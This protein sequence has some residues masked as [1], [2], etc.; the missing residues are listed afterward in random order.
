MI[1]KEWL[2]ILGQIKI[3]RIKNL[4]GPNNNCRLIFTGEETAGRKIFC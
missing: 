3:V 2:M 4:L 1:R